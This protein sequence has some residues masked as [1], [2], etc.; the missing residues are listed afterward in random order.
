MRLCDEFMLHLKLKKRVKYKSEFVSL[1]LSK[2]FVLVFETRTLKQ[3]D[4][5]S[6]MVE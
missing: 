1:R 4:S 5:L 2:V 3:G 6:T